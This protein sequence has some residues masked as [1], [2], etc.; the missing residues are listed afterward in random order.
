MTATGLL[1]ANSVTNTH[2]KSLYVSDNPVLPKVGKAE[3][4]FPADET[5]TYQLH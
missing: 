1:N 4:Y 3:Q 2:T 5:N